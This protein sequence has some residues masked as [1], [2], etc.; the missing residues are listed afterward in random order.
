MGKKLMFTGGGNKDS[1]LRKIFPVF[2]RPTN[3]G[4]FLKKHYKREKSKRVRFVRAQ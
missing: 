2:H 4:F 1:E 3:C